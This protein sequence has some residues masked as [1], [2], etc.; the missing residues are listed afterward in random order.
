MS[1]DIVT[2]GSHRPFISRSKVLIIHVGGIW[3]MAPNERDALTPRGKGYVASLLQHMSDFEHETMPLFDLLEYDTLLDSSDMEP[4]EWVKIAEDIK[5]NYDRYDGFLILHGT[6]TLVYTANALSFLLNDLNKA[7]VLTGGCLPLADTTS[8]SARHLTL[9]LLFA[10][11]PFLCEVCIFFA[12]TLLRAPCAVQVRNVNSAFVT[13]HY[14][15]LAKAS[16]GTYGFSLRKEFCKQQPKRRMTVPS[17]RFCGDVLSLQVDIDSDFEGITAL[18]RGRGK[19]SKSPAAAKTRVPKTIVALEAHPFSMDSE[20]L[21]ER[22]IALGDECEMRGTF[23]LIQSLSL[24]GALHWPRR[25]TERQAQLFQILSNMPS[26]CLVKG[27]NMTREAALIKAMYLVGFGQ[28]NGAQ[29]RRL[30]MVDLCGELSVSSKGGFKAVEE[31]V[32][33]LSH[34]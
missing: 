18:I 30:M 29:L 17:L 34:L 14:P 15:S 27:V 19:A 9:S 12:D 22:F 26:V 21:L 13:P 11:E 1:L 24:D 25:M 20:A 16:A 23:L 10:A 5:E 7:V 28:W 4:A 8:D 2:I 3:S 31:G 33:S 6:D 32:Q